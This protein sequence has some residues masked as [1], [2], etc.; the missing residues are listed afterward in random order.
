MN[1]QDSLG[2]ATEVHNPLAV[3]QPGEQVVCEIKRHP[4]G[5]LGVYVVSGFL[6][7]VLV[8]L[9]FI[10]A[11]AVFGGNR[12]AVM[13]VGTAF[14]LIFGAIILGFVFI[15]NKVYWGNRWV[16]TS[17]SI[18]QIAQ[19]SLFNKQSSQLSFGNLEDVTAE[20]EGFFAQIFHFGT[21]RN[22]TASER[23]KFLFSFC[24][25][26]TY[27]AQKILAAREA[28]E[29]SHRGG[30]QGQPG[31]G[32]AAQPGDPAQPLAFNQV[33]G[34]A[35]SASAAVLQQP[36]TP[37]GGSYQPQTA[38]QSTAAEPFPLPPTAA[39][40]DSAPSSMPNAVPIADSPLTPPPAAPI[41][42]EPFTSAESY[43]PASPPV[44]PPIFP[45]HPPAVINPASNLDQ[46]SDQVPAPEYQHPGEPPY[47]SSV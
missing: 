37:F 47:Q 32:Q 10:I 28:F 17:D 14:F 13:A 26:P 42:A 44:A 43:I 18:T 25:S 34:S 5:I 1:P 40:P 39:A 12:G 21:L 4:A 3:M 6:L 20:Q 19:T 8:V 11:P 36:S 46:T 38:G 27:Y 41:A 30:K 22:E 15:A 35:S 2:K 7:L 31:Q 33:P 16:V 9:A 23:G 29:Q 45:D 24:P